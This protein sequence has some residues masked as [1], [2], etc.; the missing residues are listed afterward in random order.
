MAYRRD[1]VAVVGSGVAGLTAAYLLQKR[2]DVTLF[3]ADDRL[4]G[5]AHT[6]E[7]P[8]DDAGTIRVDSGFIVHN[9]ATYPNLIR[10]FG[11]LDV[12]T[13]P[14]GMSMSV[15][16]EGCGLEYAGALGLS[17]VFAQSRSIA[18]PAFL[19]M[20]VEVNRFHRQAR[21]IVE[22]G[23]DLDEEV[24][25]GRFLADGGFSSYFIRHFMVPVVSAV[26]SAAPETALLYPAR[27]L[28]AFLANHGMLSV[29]GSHQW[30]T[31]A[32]GSRTYVDAIAKDL[33]EVRLSTPIRSM[34]RPP[35]GGV[36]V[37]TGDGTRETFAKAVIA[38]HPDTALG[39]L[40]QP[41]EAERRA[42]GAFRYSRNET[43]LHQDDA[44]LPRSH[45]ARAAWNY[46]L[47]DCRNDAD[48][49]LVSYDMNRLQHLPGRRPYV[50]TLN[51]SERIDEDRVIARMTYEHPIYTPESVR[52]Q[53]ELPGLNDGTVAFAGAY[54][55]WGFHED[56]C[57]AGVAAAESLGS[58]W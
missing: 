52:A 51:A 49:V 44:V 15:R 46:L 8:S 20:L 18:R 4:G 55:S 35:E 26:W 11:R 24:T 7:H 56:G 54:H 43:V 38:T 23:S 19:R 22:G 47:D 34:A 42:L 27:Y 13:V 29:K 28:F 16:C 37:V 40:A 30:Y 1:R 2:F 32:G 36:E 31:V 25:L 57:R 58:G 41:T 39:L 10:L 3:E 5:H 17:G 50:V 45:K 48:R 9:R 21:R 33:S 53:K 14:T 6:H 12:P